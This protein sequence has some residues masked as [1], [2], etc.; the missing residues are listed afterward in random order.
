M[1][2]Q[3]YVLL[4]IEFCVRVDFQLFFDG[5][6]SLTNVL[7][8]TALPIQYIVL[9]EK[10]LI[11]ASTVADM[12]AVVNTL[13]TCIGLCQLQALHCLAWYNVPT[14]SN[15]N[16]EFM[17]IFQKQNSFMSKALDTDTLTGA[18]TTRQLVRFK[19]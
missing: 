15:N 5:P 4:R 16:F 8:A 11:I 18:F 7:C 3:A 10:S 6:R 12:H 17:N 14:K 13:F 1:L 9:C 2:K 19:D